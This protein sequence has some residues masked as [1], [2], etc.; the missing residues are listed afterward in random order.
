MS[1]PTLHLTLARRVD[2]V[3]SHLPAPR[4]NSEDGSV[5][6]EGDGRDG[7]GGRVGNFWIGGVHVGVG[8]RTEGG[9]GLDGEERRR[10]ARGGV[11][12]GTRW[13]R[14]ELR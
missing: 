2:F 10:E 3:E 12:G 11:K 13:V 14:L 8:G 6:G 7:V 1:V 5:G 4:S 9:H